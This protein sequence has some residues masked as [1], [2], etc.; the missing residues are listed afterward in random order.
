MAE[1]LRSLCKALSSILSPGENKKG[2]ETKQNKTKLLINCEKY[3]ILFLLTTNFVNMRKFSGL[4]EIQKPC[5]QLTLKIKLY[6]T[7]HGYFLGKA[8]GLL[9]D[10]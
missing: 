9:K 7:E 1:C 2:I 8:F 5:F 3:L 6:T 4:E 10:A